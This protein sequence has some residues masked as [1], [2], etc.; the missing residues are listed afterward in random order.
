MFHRV[1]MLTTLTTFVFLRASPS[2]FSACVVQF[3]NSKALKAQEA[4]MISV[5]GLNGYFS[6]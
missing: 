1:V 5:D 4:E 3:L 2:L 6:R